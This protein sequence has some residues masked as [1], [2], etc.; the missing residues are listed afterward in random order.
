MS[1]GS[2]YYQRMPYCK[3]NSSKFTIHLHQVWSPQNGSH[4]MSPDSPTWRIFPVSK[5]FI[6]MVIASPCSKIRGHALKIV[7]H[8]SWPLCHPPGCLQ[9]NRQVSDQ[10]VP[11]WDPHLSRRWE[12]NDFFRVQ[13]TRGKMQSDAKNPSFLFQKNSGTKYFGMQKIIIF[14]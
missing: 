12:V 13:K 10:L 7:H 6:I 14:F 1:P 4:L 9:Q 5:W 11:V 8:E 3:G 2:L